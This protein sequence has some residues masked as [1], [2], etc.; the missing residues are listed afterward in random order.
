MPRCRHQ[1]CNT[2]SLTNNAT[3]HLVKKASYNKTDIK[4]SSSS[5]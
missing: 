5:V 2:N 1:L 3:G 4:L